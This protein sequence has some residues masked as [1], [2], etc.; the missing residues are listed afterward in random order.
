[1]IL[2]SLEQCASAIIGSTMRSPA[3]VIRIG[4]MTDTIVI[5]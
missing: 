1:M 2:A 4:L 3:A 5:D